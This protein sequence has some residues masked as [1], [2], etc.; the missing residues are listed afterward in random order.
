MWDKLVRLQDTSCIVF[1]MA[2]NDHGVTRWWQCTI[3][4]QMDVVQCLVTLLKVI[5]L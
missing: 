3:W 1:Y 2:N 4:M 5:I